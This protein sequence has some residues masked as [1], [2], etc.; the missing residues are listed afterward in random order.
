MNSSAPLVRWPFNLMMTSPG[1]MPAR[2]ASPPRV[3]RK[4]AA[5]LKLT[6]KLKLFSNRVGDITNRHAQDALVNLLPRR[7][8]SQR[9]PTSGNAL[10]VTVPR[11]SFW[12]RTYLIGISR[13][14]PAKLARRGRSVLSLTRSLLNS[15]ITSPSCNPASSAGPPAMISAIKA[16]SVF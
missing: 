14:T 3:T 10:S 7:L 11:R 13:S 12:L 6:F 1:R 2:A 4:I 9:R 15:T 5:P 8:C 16:P